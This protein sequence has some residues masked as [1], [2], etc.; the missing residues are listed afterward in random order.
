MFRFL[1]AATSMVVVVASLLFFSGHA[2]AHESRMVGPYRFV[3][4]FLTE[5]AFA[6]AA[7]GLDLRITD[8]R[9]NPATPVEG[10]EKTLTATVTSGG[11]APLAIEIKTRFGQPGAYA[12]HFVPTASGQYV[13]NIK[14]KIGTQDVNEKFE[15]GPGRFGDVESTSALQYPVKVPVGDE[16]S[17]KLDALQSTA[18]Q[19]RLFA[20]AAFVLAIVAL[21]GAAFVGR[22]RT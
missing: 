6:G 22:R 8:T 1:N 18:D 15:S 13:Y 20:I 12:A 5:P 11:V 7:N 2:Y 3:V 21:G 19:T 4:G 9:N 14:G 16:L 10:L 17:T